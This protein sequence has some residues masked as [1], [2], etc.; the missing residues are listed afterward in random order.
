MIHL[1]RFC[2]VLLL[3]LAAAT[4]QSAAQLKNELKTKETAAKKDPQKLYE[5]GVWAKEKALAVDAK[6]IFEA[7]VKIKPDH[8][9]AHE[10]LGDELVEGKWMSAKDADALRKKALAAEY[11]AKGFVDVA[12]VWVEKEKAA[13]A[14]RGVF[15]HDG[16]VVGKE[17]LVALQTGKVRHPDTG[18]LIDAKNLEKAQGK[19]YPAGSDRWVDVKE[20]DTFH[21]DPRRPWV[22]RSKHG[23][24]VSTLGLAK[25]DELKGL[26][27]AAVEKVQPVVGARVTPASLRPFV[28]VAATEAE[29][30]ELGQ[31]LG[32]GTDACGVFLMN[33]EATLKLPVIGDVRAAICFNHKEWGQRYI[34]HAAAIAY[35]HGVA[36]DGGHDLPPWLLQGI[37]A[38][39]SRLDNDHD[40][41]WF[42][43][44]HVKKG[45]VRNLKS[46]FAG[47]AISGE[48][49]SK[50]IDYNI[51]QAGLL[52]AYC[53]HG[54]DA[55]A[56]EAMKAVTDVLSGT[57][58]GSLD[59]AVTKLQTQLMEDEA[60]VAAYLQQVIAK[61]S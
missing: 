41:S 29:Y 25:I 47:F 40:A 53:L 3:V 1:L 60:K 42:G 30:R 58:K 14:K 20:A 37:G 21:S 32:D 23:T 24:F 10:A 38:Y 57:A 51:F 16:Q 50:E 6:R 54:G 46:F 52:V 18:E 33:E 28:M 61:G 5:V 44:Q 8:A 17:E 12:G 56:T 11:A 34:R 36:E 43:D 15:W 4:G 7:V 22:V 9:G 26:V 49:E 13:D 55:K 19:Y 39:T 2:L 31:Q 59:K 48:M 27:D 45:G 35:A